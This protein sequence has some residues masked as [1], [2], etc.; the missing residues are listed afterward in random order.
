MQPFPKKKFQR[1]KSMRLN[2][3]SNLIIALT[4]LEMR[5]FA[6]SNCSGLNLQC[7]ST[8]CMVR[9]DEHNI[10]QRP[11]PWNTEC[12]D[13]GSHT[14]ELWPIN[15]SYTPIKIHW[16]AQPGMTYSY[17]HTPLIRT[18]R[19]GSLAPA[20]DASALH[21]QYGSRKGSELHASY[22]NRSFMAL[23]VSMKTNAQQYKPTTLQAGILAHNKKSSATGALHWTHAIK[24]KDLYHRKRNGS[25]LN[26]TGELL[27]PLGP[28]VLRQQIN[29]DWPWHQIHEESA[30]AFPMRLGMLEIGVQGDYSRFSA[31]TKT[32]ITNIAPNLRV[33]YFTGPFSRLG[34]EW[35]GPSFPHPEIWEIAL[36]IHLPIFVKAK[37][38]GRP[39]PTNIPS[40][41]KVFLARTRSK[42]NVSSLNALHGTHQELPPHRSAWIELMRSLSNSESK[43]TSKCE[44]DETMIQGLCLKDHCAEWM[45]PDSSYTRYLWRSGIS[46]LTTNCLQYPEKAEK[47]MPDNQETGQ[48]RIWDTLEPPIS[49]NP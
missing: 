1:L 39:R 28:I 27:H 36:V 44:V 10:E 32:T 11:T 8:P 33:D 34:L 18:G 3:L 4:I 41:G 20:K 49:S 31:Q 25:S 48:L 7:Q 23:E 43:K 37:P 6:S 45:R 13:S 21:I 22:G 15:H 29:Y 47:V 42:D 38:H 12:L 35:L 9:L 19:L 26:L 40:T 5:L 17:E 24:Q 30:C 2:Q 14:L 16:K 46:E